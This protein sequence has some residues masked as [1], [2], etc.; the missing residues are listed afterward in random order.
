M[1]LKGWTLSLAAYIISR[2]AVLRHWEFCDG[3]SPRPQLRWN[4]RSPALFIS[5]S[6]YLTNLI[7]CAK[8]IRKIIAG[9]KGARPRFF[10]HADD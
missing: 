8:P 7:G 4:C 9:Q 10:S 2:T 3:V 5:A 1:K 6:T